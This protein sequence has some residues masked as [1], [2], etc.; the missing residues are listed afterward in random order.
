[1]NGSP[2]QAVFAAYLEN[3]LRQSIVFDVEASRRNLNI[4]RIAQDDEPALLTQDLES[5][6]DAGEYGPRIK[7]LFLRLRECCEEE[8]TGDQKQFLQDHRDLIY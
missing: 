8:L 1:M 3:A 6:L 5:E 7:T 2:E 4:L